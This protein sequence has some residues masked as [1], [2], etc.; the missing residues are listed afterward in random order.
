GA[1]DGGD[2]GLV[3]RVLCGEN[4]RC[5]RLP[6]VGPCPA[7]CGGTSLRADVTG[8]RQHRLALGGHRLEQRCLDQGE[9]GATVDHP[10]LAVAVAP[11]GGDDLRLVLLDHCRVDV[12]EGTEPAREAVALVVEDR[13][14]RRQGGDGLDV[15]DDFTGGC[16]QCRCE[17]CDVRCGPGRCCRLPGSRAAVDQHG[18]D[19]GGDPVALVVGGDCRLGIVG[20]LEEGHLDALAEVAG[21]VER[22]Q[23]EEGSHVGRRVPRGVGGGYTRRRRPGGGRRRVRQGEA[24]DLRLAGGLVVVGLLEVVQP[25]D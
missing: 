10:V 21:L 25:E 7:D 6:Q 14:L 13:G 2:E 5:G 22:V 15:Q 3:A 9:V 4:V 20:Q 17:I 23:V 16:C 18:C 11:A 1:A 24:A 19:G 12:E 8:R